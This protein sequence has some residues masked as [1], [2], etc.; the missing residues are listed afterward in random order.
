MLIKTSLIVLIWIKN[1]S[2]CDAFKSFFRNLSQQ[3][4]WVLSIFI[5]RFLILRIPGLK[6]FVFL[7]RI[8]S[9]LRH[10]KPL[11]T[12][13]HLRSDVSNFE[14]DKFHEI[15]LEENFFFVVRFFFE[16]K[17]LVFSTSLSFKHAAVRKSF[18]KGSRT[19]FFSYEAKVNSQIIITMVMNL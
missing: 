19:N 14:I 2:T 7:N 9:Q 6:M 17:K 4:S 16:G 3:I 11:S 10:R 1:S 8:R 18:K 12:L 5:C 15:F 13:L